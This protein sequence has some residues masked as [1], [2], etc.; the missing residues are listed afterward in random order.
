MK[1]EE[2]ARFDIS[3]KLVDAIKT[4]P[5]HRTYRHC[6]ADITASPFDIYANCPECGARIKLRSFSA[7]TGIED[8]FE[9]VFEWMSNPVARELAAER[10]A[11]MEADKDE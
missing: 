7:A 10:I 6:G 1:L 9:A 5:L 4:F 8:V 2:P 11:A 3:P